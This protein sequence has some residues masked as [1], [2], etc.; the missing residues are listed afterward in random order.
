MYM[1]ELTVWRRGAEQAFFCGDPHHRG[2]QV[3]PLGSRADA[4]PTVPHRQQC[5][6]QPNIYTR[7]KSRS[8]DSCPKARNNL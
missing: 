3:S 1:L 2:L 8:E 4:D 6:S 5:S 7:V